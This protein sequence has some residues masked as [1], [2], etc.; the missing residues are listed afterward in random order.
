[1]YMLLFITYRVTNL[2]DSHHYLDHHKL[3][4]YAKLEVSK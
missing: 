3:S 4:Y 2:Q 1:M